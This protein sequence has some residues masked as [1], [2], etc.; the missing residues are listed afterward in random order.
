MQFHQIKHGILHVKIHIKALRGTTART[1][2]STQ[3]NTTFYFYGRLT[4]FVYRYV[5]VDRRGS[6]DQSYAGVRWRAVIMVK[7]KW[8]WTTAVLFRK[9]NQQLSVD[10]CWDM[11]MDIHSFQR[12]YTIEESPECRFGPYI[13]WYTH[14]ECLTCLIFMH[15]VIT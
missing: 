1:R 5:S 9:Q 6:L 7:K 2:C 12:R 3:W 11:D 13:M 10:I 4:I 14:F 8:T 15:M